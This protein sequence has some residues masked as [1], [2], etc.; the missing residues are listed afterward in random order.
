MAHSK[1]RKK[2]L[3]KSQAQ[4]LVNRAER[5]KMRTAV[6]KARVA[7]TEDPD[8]ADAALSAATKSLDKAGKRNLIHRNKASRLKS[9]LAKARNRAAAE[10]A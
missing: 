9:R 6:K 10:K 2:T 7:V 1:H 5:S 3:R 8:N 4:R